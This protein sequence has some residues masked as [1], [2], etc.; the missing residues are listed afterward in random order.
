MASCQHSASR[1]RSGG[2][3]G[4]AI[5]LSPSKEATITVQAGS[6]GGRGGGGEVVVV[7]VSRDK[8]ER[9]RGEGGGGGGWEKKSYNE[10]WLLKKN[11][12]NEVGGGGGGVGG[13]GDLIPEIDL[14]FL[15]A[16]HGSSKF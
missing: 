12:E 2:T 7:V 9:R 8:G 14:L 11:V 5:F 16:V 15:M 1:M 3:A 13:R 4:L 6:W 10:K